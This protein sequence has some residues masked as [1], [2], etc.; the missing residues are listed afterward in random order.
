MVQGLSIATFRYAPAELRDGS[1]AAEEYLDALN[2]ELNTRLKRGGRVFL[3]NA[4]LRGK[5][6]LRACIVNFR[7]RLSDV[8]AV[9]EIVAAEGRD[10]DR[11]MRPA[12][13]RRGA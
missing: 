3:T 13:L 8:E 7:T 4:V 10:L 6:V 1:K 11:A 12:A 5:F 9:P 2:R